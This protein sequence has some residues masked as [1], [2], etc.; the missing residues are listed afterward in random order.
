MNKI[1]ALKAALDGKKINCTN[2]NDP[3]GGYLFWDSNRF[4]YHCNIEKNDFDYAH[5]L[6]F[7]T[8][9]QILPTLVDFATALKAFEQGKTIRATE[10]SI[11]GY[12]SY[13]KGARPNPAFTLSEI[14]GKWE[15][16]ED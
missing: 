15:I 6:C 11:F 12:E 10:K 16:M 7:E 5:L 2:W 13:Q 3:Q 1:E 14:R 8:G 9:W 4:F